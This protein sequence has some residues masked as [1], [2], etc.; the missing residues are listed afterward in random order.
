[1]KAK[2]EFKALQ[3]KYNANNLQVTSDFK[4]M[5]ASQVKCQASDP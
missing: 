4:S 1:M 3:I 2:P 5:T